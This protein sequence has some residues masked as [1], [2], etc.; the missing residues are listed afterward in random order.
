MRTFH[1]LLIAVAMTVGLVACGKQG[2]L[3]PPPGYT[4]PSEEEAEG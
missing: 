2:P 1:T 4:P 3:K